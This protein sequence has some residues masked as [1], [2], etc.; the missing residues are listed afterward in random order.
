MQDG[1]PN[2]PPPVTVIAATQK[3]LA[4]G[5][6]RYDHINGL[7]ALREAICEHLEAR[8]GTKCNPS[9]LL[10]ANGSSQA[11]FQVFQCL[12]DPGDTVLVPSPAW[13]SYIQGIRMAGGIPVSYRCGNDGID[14]DEIRTH[15]IAK[16][17]LIVVNSP[18]NPTGA[19]LSLST[20]RKLI[21][22]CVNNDVLIL[23]DAAYEDY[24]FQETQHHDLRT[25]AAEHKS[26]VLTT[27]S[28]S[29]SYSMTG[30]RIGYLHAERQYIERCAALQTHLSDNVCTFAQFGAIAALESPRAELASRA[31]EIENRALDAYSALAEF[32]PCSQPKGGFF[33]FPNISGLMDD[34]WRNCRA[35]ALDLARVTGVRVV[36]GAD[37]GAPGHIRMSIASVGLDQIRC[38]ISLLRSFVEGKV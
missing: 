25:V 32:I 3:A 16:P 30:F 24:V 18:H 11:I 31:Q 9:E 35:F 21:E 27:R 8:Y 38:G 26:M 29:K 4:G 19:V 1:E 15:M 37:F 17:K 36:A 34:R 10:V 33:L 13:P 6:T 7:S 2:F 23:S 12:V 22:I 20:L 5:H 14:L 28:F